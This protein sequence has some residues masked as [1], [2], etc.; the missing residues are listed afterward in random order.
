MIQKKN[1]SNAEQQFFVFLLAGKGF[2]ITR[3]LFCEV[4]AISIALLDSDPNEWRLF[5]IHPLW[6]WSGW[7]PSLGLHRPCIKLWW[8]ITSGSLTDPLIESLSRQRRLLVLKAVQYW[9]R[10]CSFFTY[11]HLQILQYRYTYHQAYFVIVNQ[12]L[13]C[14][15]FLEPP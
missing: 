2:M 7:C 8:C 10:A 12:S 14:L 1:R 9:V 4:R 13:P 15:I 6:M 11:S 5:A 3:R